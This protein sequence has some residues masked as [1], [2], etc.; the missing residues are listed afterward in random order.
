[1]GPHDASHPRTNSAAA[2]AMTSGISYVQCQNLKYNVIIMGWL[3]VIFSSVFLGSS[4]LTMHLQPDIELLLAQWP[5]NLVPVSE[6]QLLIKCKFEGIY[7]RIFLIYL[8]FNFNYLL[9]FPW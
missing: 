9:T 7:N 5:L 1:M 4:A 6:Q 8:V 2:L 3:G